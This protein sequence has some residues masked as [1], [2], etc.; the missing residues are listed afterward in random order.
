MLRK[1]KDT[2]AKNSRGFI[3][4]L[5]DEC[6]SRILELTS[7]KECSAVQLSH[8]LNMPIS[9]V[10]KKLRLLEEA[11][12]IQNVKTLIDRAGNHEKY[13]RCIVHDAT[14]NFRDGEISMSFEKVDYK[15]GLVTLWKNLGIRKGTKTAPAY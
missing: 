12:V 5:A 3:E 1:T 4:F 11:E 14:V 10:Y 8:E 6:S 15:N 9:T 7:R 2:G 13:Y